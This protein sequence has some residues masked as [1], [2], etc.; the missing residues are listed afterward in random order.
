MP[1]TL[2]A[3][4]TLAAA[5]PRYDFFQAV[6][7]LECAHAS[8][9][10]VGE[11]PRPRDDFVRFSQEPELCFAPTT[12]AGFRPISKL[13]GGGRLVVNF[14]GLLGPNGPLPIHL[15]EYARERARYA[16][17]ATFARFLDVFHHRMVA[18]FYRAWAQA[19][20][21]VSLDRAGSDRFSVY[22]G[23]T[24][25]LV[26]RGKTLEHDRDVDS[27]TDRRHEAAVPDFARLHF[28][29]LLA[30]PTRPA[31]GL[32]QVLARFFGLPVRIEE[33]VGH[34]MTLPDE[35]HTHLGAPDGASVL[36]SSTMLGARVWDR[37]NKFR[38]VIGPVCLTDYL[39]FLPCGASLARLI[40]W[41]RGY[42][43][44]PLD[45][46]VRLVLRRAEV[47]RLALGQQARLG[48]TTWIAGGPARRD[49]DD[50][51]FAPA[52]VIARQCKP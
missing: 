51:V 13:P 16:G 23:S 17:D 39:R 30:L 2:E 11:S 9:P 38:I 35:A 29:G 28:A 26:P 46:D 27:E 8:C 14:M 40:E 19:Q 47:P 43:R 36:G 21:A 44:D 15:T 37:Q 49:A 50:L 7:L 45:W 20:P 10:R 33:G 31:V 3:S 4:Q 25:G 32:Q 41:V 18:L 34:W 12:L 48:H 22:V 52:P 24:F 6:R 1:D 42:L 5:A